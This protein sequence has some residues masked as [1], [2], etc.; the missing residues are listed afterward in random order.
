MLKVYLVRIK[1]KHFVIP[2]LN[3]LAIGQSIGVVVTEF[4]FVKKPHKGM[5]IY[6]YSLLNS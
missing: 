5:I 1:Q 6:V 3:Q 2:L 4:G